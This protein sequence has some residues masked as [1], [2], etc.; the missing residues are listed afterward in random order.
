[1]RTEQDEHEEKQPWGYGVLLEN[2]I[3]Q[4]IARAEGPGGIVGDY[5]EEIPL[6]EIESRGLRLD[7]TPSWLG[8]QVNVYQIEDDEPES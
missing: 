4:V 8:E 7:H 1:M 5:L 2:G 3:L 6:D